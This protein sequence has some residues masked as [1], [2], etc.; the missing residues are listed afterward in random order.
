MRQGLQGA[1]EV[2]AVVLPTGRV[3][4][5][6]ITKSIDNGQYGLDQ[7][8]L[9]AAKRWEFRPGRD[10]N[11]NAVP[12]I[13]TMIFDMRL[14]GGAVW[15]P[16]EVVSAP[17][18]ALT[19]PARVAKNVPVYP[20][21]ARRA[22]TEATVVVETDTDETGKVVSARLVGG[23]SFFDDVLLASAQSWTFTPTLV[24]G[25]AVPTT[26]TTTVRFALRR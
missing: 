26:V 19:L 16:L 15:A 1:I 23:S 10:R 22:G 3:G 9:D 8:A 11:G 25:V 21:F 20:D 7:A 6:R 14:H 13:V 18:G 5:A 4:D 24:D 12:V 17:Q 2:E